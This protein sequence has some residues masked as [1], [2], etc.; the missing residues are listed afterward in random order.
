MIQWSDSATLK[1]T[2]NACLRA[3]TNV[4]PDSGGTGHPTYEY[5]GRTW[6]IALLKPKTDADLE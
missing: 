4:D 5:L 1:P 2:S 3:A 6:L